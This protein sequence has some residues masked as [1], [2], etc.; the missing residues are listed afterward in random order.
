MQHFASEQSVAF[1]QSPNLKLHF[2]NRFT[3]KH[4]FLSLFSRKS[5]FAVLKI[6]V[7][8]SQC[9]KKEVKT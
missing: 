2:I 7:A 5:A 1:P 4:T 9:N 3:P 6:S 8:A